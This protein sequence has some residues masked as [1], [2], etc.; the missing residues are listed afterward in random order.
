VLERATMSREGGLGST[1]EWSEAHSAFHDAL[2]AA[3]DSPRLLTLTRS[4]RNSAELY[5]QLSAV[6][7]VESGRNLAAEH[8]ELMELATTR[9]VREAQAAL[10][11]HI[12]ITTDVVLATALADEAS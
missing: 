10:A 2:V 4:L 8:F 5:R 7:Q 3:C 9:R 11:R 12:Q 1:D 6:G